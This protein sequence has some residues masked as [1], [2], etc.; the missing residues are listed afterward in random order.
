MLSVAHFRHVSQCL[1]WEGEVVEEVSVA[2]RLVIQPS[3]ERLLVRP[4]SF[5]SLLP[6]TSCSR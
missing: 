5:F 4:A 6:V 2:G 1:W 3:G